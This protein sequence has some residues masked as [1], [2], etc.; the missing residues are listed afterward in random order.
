VILGLYIKVSG[1]PSSLADVSDVTFSFLLR[2]KLFL[3]FGPEFSTVSSN[4][5]SANEFSEAVYR[6]TKTREMALIVFLKLAMVL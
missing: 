5:A 2:L 3:S 1:R 4:K 6:G